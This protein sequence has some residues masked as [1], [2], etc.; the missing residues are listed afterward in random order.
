MAPTVKWQRWDSGTYNYLDNT[1]AGVM[2]AIEGELDTWISACNLNAS[3]TGR[4][5]TRVSTYSEGSGTLMGLVVK[6]QANNNTVEG[7]MS[8]LMSG[9]SSRKFHVSTG[10]TDDTGNGGFGTPTGI[11]AQ[12]TSMSWTSSGVE[13]NFLIVY[14]STDGQEFFCVTQKLGTSTN[15]QDGVL[16][17]KT[18]EGEWAAATSDGGT[19]YCGHYSASSNQFQN[20]GGASSSTTCGTLRG[21]AYWYPRM[22]LFSNVSSGP[23][24]I[25]TDN[26]VAAASPWLYSQ[27]SSATYGQVGQRVLLTDLGDGTNVYTLTLSYNAFLCLIDLRP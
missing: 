3:N 5:L 13:A 27:D 1:S 2:A 26:L 24:S 10:F 23:N 14:D 16:M 9:A 20:V 22:F 7:Y 21:G 8:L 6:M 15:Y 18:T 19:H 4:Q 17:F 12:D 25:G 11:V